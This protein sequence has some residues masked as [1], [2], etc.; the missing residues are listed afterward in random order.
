MWVNKDKIK[1]P[2]LKQAVKR[3]LRCITK[4]QA[5]FCLVCQQED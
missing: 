2:A 1:T 5:F 4:P 3:D